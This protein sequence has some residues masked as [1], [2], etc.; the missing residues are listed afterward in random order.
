MFTFFDFSEEDGGWTETRFTGGPAVVA[1]IEFYP[2]AGYESRSKGGT[3]VGVNADKTEV[4]LATITSPPTLAWNAVPLI[5]HSTEVV[6]VKYV[7]P[8][9]SWCNVGEIK[10]YRKC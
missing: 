7:G 10:V 4:K 6:G 5:K 8:S 3:F 1:H 9:G 2:R